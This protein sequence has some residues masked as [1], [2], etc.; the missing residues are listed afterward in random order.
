MP[1]RTAREAV[2]SFQHQPPVETPGAFCFPA[3]A[4]SN[5]GGFFYPPA[6]ATPRTDA[7]TFFSFA[8]KGVVAH[9]HS[10]RD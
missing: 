5:H 6:K 3:P 8:G 4:L 2:F 1:K 9:G 10:P 7:A